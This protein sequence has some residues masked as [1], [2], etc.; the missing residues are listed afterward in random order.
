MCLCTNAERPIGF[1]YRSFCVVWGSAGVAILVALVGHR[2]HLLGHNRSLCLR[3]VV[4]P[5]DSFDFIGCQKSKI[6]AAN[7]C[8]LVGDV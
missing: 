4:S 3:L 1:T 6:L 5:I 8:T 7:H 2:R